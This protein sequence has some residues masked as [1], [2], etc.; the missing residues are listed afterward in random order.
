MIDK[1][2]TSYYNRHAPYW[3]VFAFDSIMI[4]GAFCLSYFVRFNLSFNFN[5][6]QLFYQLPVVLM[7]SSISFLTFGCYKSALRYA[8]ISDVTNVFKSVSLMLVLL[9]VFKYINHTFVLIPTFTI[10]VSI[11][12]MHA[13]LSLVFLSFSRVFFKAF[14]NYQKTKNLSV[15][16]VLI[17]GAGES[18]VA[19][20]NTVINNNG[21]EKFKVIGFINDGHLKIRKHINGL[22]VFPESK[23]TQEFILAYD[24]KDI[25]VR[26]QDSTE[27]ELVAF[28]DLKVNIVKIHPFHC[29]VDG[30]LTLNKLK[31]VN[32]KDLLGRLPIE[33]HNTNV[34]KEFIG[35]TLLITGA[36]SPIGKE[37]VYR[38][39]NFDIKKVVLIDHSESE[40]YDLYE[41]LKQKGKHN[42]AT[43]VADIS[44]GL[45]IDIL[46]QEYKPTV[47]FHAAEYTNENLLEKSPYEAIKIN[48]NGTKFLADTAA[49]YNV[50]KFIY[51]SNNRAIN[52]F[53]SVGVTKRLG[54]LYLLCLQKAS[55]TK[56][57]TVRYGNLVDSKCSIISNF[58]KQIQNG[59]PITIPH[60]NMTKYFSTC[61][62]VVELIL[63]AG[64]MGK[65]GE[66]FVFN[67]GQPVNIYHLAKELI[68]LSGLGYKKDIDIK[69]TGLN[70]AEKM[71]EEFI[72]NIENPVYTYH[73]KIMIFNSL[74]LNHIKLKSKIEELCFN[75][76]FQHSDIIVKMKKLISESEPYNSDHEHLY[77]RVQSYKRAKGIFPEETNQLNIK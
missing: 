47:V 62:E 51:V 28:K 52:P 76:R 56:F 40:L 67:T 11:L 53:G 49:R 60:A 68:R 13:F 73:K 3:L 2:F 25:L 35:E 57:V 65:G 26:P 21:L 18:G 32:L 58:E 69:V 16:K 4:I 8:G 29:W 39:I 42:F 20:Y 72:A 5:V 59:G 17:Y 22:P 61:Q 9:G 45:R 7:A 66:V 33:I 36:A 41:D 77:R 55:V 10:P 1:Q 14:Y 70:P 50:K 6:G 75:N 12:I 43:I 15:R 54:E 30:E 44:D 48:I 27:E 64:T 63:E 23:I 38:V 24:I 71:H 37:L 19:L 46:F 31:K 34:A 74:E